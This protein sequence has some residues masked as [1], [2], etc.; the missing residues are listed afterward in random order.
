MI[1]VVQAHPL[2]HQHARTDV[3]WAKLTQVTHSSIA[4]SAITR[5][6]SSQTRARHRTLTMLRKEAVRSVKPGLKKIAAPDAF[7]RRYGFRLRGH[8]TAIIK[9]S[10][11]LIVH[12]DRD[13]FGTVLS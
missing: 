3:N 7:L 6:L 4:A 9:D 11:Y 5:L 2:Q 8:R 12:G 1:A 13:T 10:C